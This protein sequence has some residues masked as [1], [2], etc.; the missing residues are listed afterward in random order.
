[1]R[2]EYV[3][4]QDNLPINI[5]LVEIKEYPLHWKDSIE[6]VFV[7]DGEIEVGIDDYSNNL[8]AGEIEIINIDEVRWF[9]GLT[10][11]NR[12]LLVDIEPSFFERFY[13]DARNTF[14]YTDVNP[15]NKRIDNDKNIKLKEYISRLLFEIEF[16]PENYDEKIEEELLS[17]M[18]FLLNNYHY[19]FYE[20]ENLKEDDVQLE[21]HHRIIKYL[22]KNYMNKVSLQEIADKEHLSPQ[23]LSYKIK[24]TF[25]LGFND[26]LNQIRVKA[27]TKL[28]LTTDRSISDISNEVGFSHVRYF[29][30]HFELNYNMDPAEYREKYKIDD[31]ELE[32]LKMIDDMNLKDAL[33][34]VSP[35]IREYDRYFSESKIYRMDVD[36]ESEILSYY[37]KPRIINLSKAVYL[38]EEENHVLLEE[39]QKEIGFKYGIV[40]DVFSSD[41]GIYNHG[42]FVNWTKIS[43]LLEYII[44]IDLIPIINID[45]V[46]KEVLDEFV[47][48]FE[49]RYHDI[50]NWLVEKESMN[51]NYLEDEVS[52]LY[53]EISM[54]P[55]I[56]DKYL[57]EKKQ[58]VL[59]Y[60]D[61]ISE[62]TYITNDTFFG[63]KGLFTNNGLNKGS[64][65]ALMLLALLGDEIIYTEHGCIVTRSCDGFEVLVYNDL[66][67]EDIK[68]V[69]KLSV[70]LYNCTS[71]YQV[72]K[73]ILD[74]NNGSIYDKW[75]ELGSP[76]RLD[77]WNKELLKRYVHPKIHYHYRNK[78]MVIN[79]Y[80]KLKPNSA[81]L[82]KFYER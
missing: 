76:E 38:L 56:M 9:K 13:A 31:D 58:I 42:K 72:S 68:E 14:F 22:N 4:Y 57:N 55:F 29:N 30:R 80:E 53:D 16:K 50:E 24:D 69:K 21:R 66:C 41:M 28:L 7:L 49:G 46:D 62:H 3:E 77:P 25:G 44:S 74:K 27:A 20:G 71:E 70:N 34:Y 47:V 1:M 12:V 79:I 40:E 18:Y 26:F 10:T 67:H 45:G 65:Y 43:N 36:L 81:I 75:L 17:L 64:Y 8:F 39:M 52:S 82:Y 5:S 2:R 23:Y 78:A 33:V 19:L 61:R 63:G 11:N 54:T 60:K 48:N 59:D 6:I 37:E 51:L 35:Y 15:D 73:Y 32:K